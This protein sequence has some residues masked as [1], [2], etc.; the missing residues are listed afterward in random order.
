MVGYGD[1]FALN[2]FAPRERADAGASPSH[3]G[4]VRDGI[5]ITPFFRGG[6]ADWIAIS[7]SQLVLLPTPEQYAG[8]EPEFREK[9]MVIGGI[10]AISR[11]SRSRGRRNRENVDVIDAWPRR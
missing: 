4:P 3:R 7:C 1:T 6:V 8:Y 9:C 5:S 10:S 2:T 11:V